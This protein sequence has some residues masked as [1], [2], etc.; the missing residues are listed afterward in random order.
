[1]ADT[2]YGPVPAGMTPPPPSAAPPPPPPGFESYAAIGPLRSPAPSGAGGAVP[3]PP[4]PS[5]GNGSGRTFG[6]L[7]VAVLLTLALG[8]GTFFV[9]RGLIDESDPAAGRSAA[10]VPSTQQQPGPG[11][12][13]GPSEGPSDEAVPAEPFTEVE[14][15]VQQCTGG[16]PDRGV[17]GQ[18]GRFMTGGGLQVPTPE[19][20]E[21]VLDQSLAF[22]FADGVYAPSKLVEQGATTGWVAVYA[23]GSLSRGN[24]FESPRQA[25]ETVVTCM[26]QSSVFYSNFTGSTS[27]G[28]EETA[29]DGDPAWDLTQEIRVDNPELTVEGDVVR[30]VVVDTGDPASYG[31]FVSVV[32]IGDQGLIAEQDAAVGE[33]AAR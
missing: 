23:L 22:T 10:G 3:P 26:S 18:Q 33:L 19:G 15:T 9:V 32:P 7:L 17:T 16:L 11:I 30:V 1:M 21:P 25:A 2:P 8:V 28:S 20:F 14:P 4:P 27:I 24:G 29:V 13:G 5:P 6:Y 12:G 31:L